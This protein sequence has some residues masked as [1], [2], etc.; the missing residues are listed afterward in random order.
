M[1]RF[2]IPVALALAAATG[3]ARADDLYY[4]EGYRAN[5]PM[6]AGGEGI[7]SVGA[8]RFSITESQYER[9]TGRQGLA[10]GW[11]RATWACMAE[12]EECGR[13]QVDLRIT[14]ARIDI[15]F[16]G[17]RSFSGTRCPG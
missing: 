4:I 2:L 13:E 1:I 3:A 6:E 7:I 16:G 11:Q 9:V 17:G 10:D 12:G 8:G 5:C 15:R 14:E